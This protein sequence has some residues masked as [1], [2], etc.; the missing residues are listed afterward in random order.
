[1]KKLKRKIAA[2]LA[3]ILVLMALISCGAHA[4]EEPASEKTEIWEM[5]DYCAE[6]TKD[7]SLLQ[8]EDDIQE[9]IQ[10]EAIKPEDIKL[11]EADLEQEA[12][13]GVSDISMNLSVQ[14]EI[15]IPTEEDEEISDVREEPGTDMIQEGNE[16]FV[17]QEPDGNEAEKPV[18][19]DPQAEREEAEAPY[20]ETDADQDKEEAADTED[21]EKAGRM[22]SFQWEDYLRGEKAFAA[23]MFAIN[24]L[25]ENSALWA[26]ILSEEELANYLESLCKYR[27]NT[28]LEPVFSIDLRIMDEEGTDCPL[29]DNADFRFCIYTKEFQDQLK[30]AVL[31]HYLTD[32]SWEKLEFRF[33]EI[34]ESAAFAKSSDLKEQVLEEQ[35]KTRTCVEFRADSPG[36]FLFALETQEEPVF[37]RAMAS[38]DD[39]SG[40]TD[41][42][43]GEFIFRQRRDENGN[44]EIRSYWNEDV[45][46]ADPL[47]TT[48][49]RQVTY[50]W[51]DEDGVLHP[52]TVHAY[53][54]Q[55][56][57]GQPIEEDEK[58]FSADDNM[59]VPLREGSNLSKALF[60]LYG[61]PMWNKTVQN[62][63]GEDVNMKDVMDLYPPQSPGSTGNGGYYAQ[64]HF[65][66]SY[67]YGKSESVWNKTETGATIWNKAGKTFLERVKA[68]L[69]LLPDPA[70]ELRNTAGRVVTGG[71]ISASSLTKV[72]DTVYRTPVL[73]YDTYDENTSGITLPSGVSMN[74][75]G[76]AHTKKVSGITG[77]CKFTLEFNRNTYTEDTFDFML[78]CK[79]AV[80]F[81]AWKMMFGTD[82]QDIGFSYTTGDKTLGLSVE[83]PDIPQERKVEISKTSVTDSKELPGAS[84]VVKDA[85]GKVVDSW[86]SAK[87]PHTVQLVPG[88]YT[89]T[90]T[91]AP[92]GYLV[93]ETITFVVKDTDK[94]Q[95]VKMEDAP[96]VHAILVSKTVKGN[97]GNKAKE[98]RFKIKLTSYSKDTV[99]YEKNGKTGTLP[100]N[101]GIAEFTL[102]HGETIKFTEIPKGC[103]YQVEEPDGKKDG[104]RVTKKNA[105]GTMAEKDINVSFQNE[106]DGTVPTDSTLNTSMYLPFLFFALMVSSGII[107]RIRRSSS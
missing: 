99:A 26:A 76:I 107:A 45:I 29:P 50:D 11:E 1:M 67:L 74:F 97:M 31:Y 12:E 103:S 8:K 82:K 83:L 47:P 3:G 53:C 79:Y 104:Y 71:T 44:K 15:P 32:G 46:I 25:P 100:L 70:V 72:S 19:E 24:R 61:G 77:G 58:V 84:L 30:N 52:K 95:K 4:E 60:Y 48:R 34:P 27:A 68:E 87:T 94:V 65:I 35:E 86:V 102:T 7:E 62:S 17:L 33:S 22:F 41:D 105:S 80:N 40:G 36:V 38:G 75:D 56:A 10:L 20:E 63:D 101:N 89:L 49:L 54:L 73:T 13:E 5:E 106:K 57:Y 98:F 93:A 43:L 90:E 18:K 91:S 28:V 2:A 21:E 16:G 92:N 37:L 42:V 81:A 9:P 39:T 69:E 59:I 96:E 55:P 6:E 64:T 23:E 85:K 78:K 66:V 88:T 14:R 51:E